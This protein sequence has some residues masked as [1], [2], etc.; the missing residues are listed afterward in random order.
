MATVTAQ[1]AISSPTVSVPLGTV[2]LGTATKAA[3]F[4]FA[5]DVA[6]STKLE[7]STNMDL[8]PTPRLSGGDVSVVH[9]FSV[10]ELHAK[11]IPIGGRASTRNLDPDNTSNSTVLSMGQ[12]WVIPSNSSSFSTAP[13]ASDISFS[14]N[15]LEADGSPVLVT[16]ST[17]NSSAPLGTLIIP[18]KKGTATGAADPSTSTT[19]VTV[20]NAKLQAAISSTTDLTASVEFFSQDAGVVVNTPGIAAGNN[21]STP[22]V[23]T[24]F[25]PASTK[26]TSQDNGATSAVQIGS[27]TL[28]NQLL[29]TRLTELGT[30]QITGFAKVLAAGSLKVADAS[31]ITVNAA[32]L[33]SGGTPATD[34]VVTVTGS[35][36]SVD[37]GSQVAI[38]T[39]SNTTYDSVTVFGSTDGSFSA[40]LRGDC[41]VSMSITVNI[42]EQVSGTKTTVVTKTAIC[43][44]GTGDTK[45][46]EQFLTDIQAAGSGITGV[47]SYVSQQGGLAALVSKGGN[48]LKAVIQAAKTA[49]GLS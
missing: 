24:P 34:N 11:S 45:T 47:L 19:T 48:Q 5:D 23:F 39:G 32:A 16:S 38:T 31:K 4:A 8:G 43:G 14:D 17:V 25:A 29:T 2:S 46:V 7:T 18:I 9:P 44:G 15:S 30:P 33:S 41:A 10:T 6:T 12:L 49:L 42:N 26:A 27:G 28:S 13:A 22:T 21:A 20:K 3:T 1:N 36:G 40:K 37:G 35:A